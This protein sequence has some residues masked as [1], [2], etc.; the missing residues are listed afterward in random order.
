MGEGKSLVRHGVTQ[1]QVSEAR[2]LPS[3]TSSQKMELI[4]LQ[5]LE[6]RED[7]KCL[8]RFL[9]CHPTRTQDNLGGKRYVDCEE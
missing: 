2:N 6:D 3:G 8:Y 1:T 5:I 4:A 9:I 7:L